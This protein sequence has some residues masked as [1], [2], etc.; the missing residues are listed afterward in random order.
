MSKPRKEQTVQRANRT[1]S[2]SCKEQIVQRAN[3][4]KSKPHKE[5]TVQRAKAKQQTFHSHLI[6]SYIYEKIEQSYEMGE[7]K[8]K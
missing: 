1:K 6:F 2:K 8:R 3:R 5:Q 4:T 7:S